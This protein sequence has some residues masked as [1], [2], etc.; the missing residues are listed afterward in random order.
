MNE[1][2]NSGL[3]EVHG[4]FAPVIVALTETEMESTTAGLNSSDA[5]GVGALAVGISLG[6]LCAP[7]GA[8]LLI[9]YAAG[10]LGVV[11]DG[12]IAYGLAASQ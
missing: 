10:A 7:L 2:G 1:P 11:G 9:C 4:G 5:I 8:G 6:L 3:A 12:Y